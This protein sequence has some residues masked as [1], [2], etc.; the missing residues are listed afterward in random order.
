MQNE[1]KNGTSAGKEK[2]CSF[3]CRRKITDVVFFVRSGLA[4]LRFRNSSALPR[5]AAQPAQ[6]HTELFHQKQALCPASVSEYTS[7]LLR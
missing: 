3:R 6:H 2:A 1:E 4:I 7:L 5:S